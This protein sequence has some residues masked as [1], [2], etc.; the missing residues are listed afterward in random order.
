[1]RLYIQTGWCHR[2]RNLADVKH[3]REKVVSFHFNSADHEIDDLNL[4]IIEKCRENSRFYGKAREVYWIETLF[5]FC[6]G[7][8]FV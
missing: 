7:A 4:I 3:G 2:I 6:I 8:L 1:M 5:V